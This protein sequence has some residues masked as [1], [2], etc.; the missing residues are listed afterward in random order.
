MK[1][2]ET[3]PWKRYDRGAVTHLSYCPSKPNG[4]ELVQKKNFKP[5]EIKKTSMHDYVQRHLD[6]HLANSIVI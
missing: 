3:S 1:P 4:H 6:L 2:L 5:Y